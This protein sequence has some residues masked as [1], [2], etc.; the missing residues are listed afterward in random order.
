[1]YSMTN[2]A[3]VAAFKMISYVQRKFQNQFETVL[4]QVLFKCFQFNDLKKNKL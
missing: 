3:L 2:T 1:M 4:N